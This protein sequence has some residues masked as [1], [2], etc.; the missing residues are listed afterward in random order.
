MRWLAALVSLVAAIALAAP[1]RHVVIKRRG[2]DVV[3]GTVVSE[4]ETGY[5]LRLE[6][7]TTLAVKFE[8]IADLTETPPPPPGAARSPQPPGLSPPPPPPGALAPQPVP[9]AQRGPCAGNEVFLQYDLNDPQTALCIGRTEVTAGEYQACVSARVCDTDQ[10]NCNQTSTFGKP[11]RL[12]YPLNCVSALQA[13]VYCEWRRARLP[14]EDEWKEI[15]DS[16]RPGDY[17]WGDEDP[18]GRVCWSGGSLNRSGPC[19][20]GSFPKGAGRAGVLDI[21]GNVWEWTSSEKRRDRIF[22]GGAWNDKRTKRITR[23]SRN[24][25]NPTEHFED[26]G[27]RCVRQVPAPPPARY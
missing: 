10:L 7:G 5:L 9:Q 8:E 24:W 23:D 22:M 16:A 12:G 3:R 13:D 6:S 25:A 21:T 26:T 18:E 20:A 2:G 17:P 14:T 4:M 11:D 1:P 19:P 27:F 15:A